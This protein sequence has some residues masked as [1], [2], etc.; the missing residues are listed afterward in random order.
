[1]AACARRIGVLSNKAAEDTQG[2]SEALAFEAALQERGGKLGANLQIDYRWGAWPSRYSCMVRDTAPARLGLRLKLEGEA[3]DA[4]AS[5]TAPMGR[6]N[7]VE[8]TVPYSGNI[9]ILLDTQEYPAYPPPSY[10]RRGNQLEHTVPHSSNI[11]ILLGTL[12]TP[13][14]RKR[15]R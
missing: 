7:H 12:V 6:G 5:P 10:L 15:Y 14:L 3:H 11:R 8:D 4:Q 9:Q 1:V 2:R 13:L